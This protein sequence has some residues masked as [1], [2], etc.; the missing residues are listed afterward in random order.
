VGKG[1]ASG[2]LYSPVHSANSHKQ[3]W[4]WL[5]GKNDA[6]FL[7]VAWCKEDFHGLG[8]QDIAEFDSV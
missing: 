4:S 5:V 2:A 3:L 7:S 6:T 1:V 8:V